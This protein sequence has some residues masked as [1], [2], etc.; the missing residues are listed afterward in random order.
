MNRPIAWSRLVTVGA[1]TAY[2]LASCIVSGA[3]FLL[4]AA[5]VA[6]LYRTVCGRK[7]W[8]ESRHGDTGDKQNDVRR[9]GSSHH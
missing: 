6:L 7:K 8:R 9:Q 1:L 5:G 4:A 2:A 3:N